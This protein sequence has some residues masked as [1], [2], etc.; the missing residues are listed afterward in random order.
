MRNV[1]FILI[2]TLIAG[3]VFSWNYISSLKNSLRTEQTAHAQTRK[4]LEEATSRADALAENARLCLAREAQARQWS[5]ER[6]DILGKAFY[7]TRTPED[8]EKVVDNETRNAVIN[9]LNRGLRF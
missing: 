5:A 2:F 7:E 6:N 4:E 9:R 1:I 3:S 8:K